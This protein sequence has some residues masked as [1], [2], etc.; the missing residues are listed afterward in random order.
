MGKV[1]TVCERER[2]STC[3]WLSTHGLLAFVT[4]SSIAFAIPPS[5]LVGFLVQDV[6]PIILLC[7]QAGER[8]SVG[9]EGVTKALVAPDLNSQLIRVD[10]HKGEEDVSPTLTS[11]EAGGRAAAALHLAVRVA[12][13][14][15][16]PRETGAQGVLLVV[17][18]ELLLEGGRELGNMS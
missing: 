9:G 5:Q 12:Q 1:Q 3:Y 18:H 10:S 13:G 11:V 7:R 8:V 15:V 6:N 14:R 4:Y 16:H 17:V 2:E